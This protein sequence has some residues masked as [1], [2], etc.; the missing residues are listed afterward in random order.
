MLLRELLA[1]FVVVEFLQHAKA[2]TVNLPD[3]C[4]LVNGVEI[5]LLPVCR[6]AGVETVDN[7][8]GILVLKDDRWR[9]QFR[10]LDRRKVDVHLEDCALAGRSCSFRSRRDYLPVLIYFRRAQK[11]A[12]T[13]RAARP[14]PAGYP[15]VISNGIRRGWYRSEHRPR[16][17]MVNR[18]AIRSRCRSW[19]Y[20][21]YVSS[22]ENPQ[23]IRPR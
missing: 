10:L 2:S 20:D 6:L 3:F 1:P 19:L 4:D 12:A 7:H 16:T 23:C 21:R 15:D 9:L 22:Q 5:N 17:D 11:P 18:A 14:L 13:Q 8:F